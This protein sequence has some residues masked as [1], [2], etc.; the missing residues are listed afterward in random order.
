VTALPRVAS[1]SVPLPLRFQ[2]GARTLGSIRRRMVRV[3]LTL[4]D[5]LQTEVP[6]LPPLERGAHGYA[7]T[8]LP[9]A[10]AEGMARPGMLGFVRQSYNRYYT[11][12][13]IGFDAWFG[14]LS[15]SA[16]ATLK[17]KRRKLADAAGGELD[18]RAYRTPEDLALFHTIARRIS[19]RTY[20]ERLMGSGLPDDP[21]FVQRMYAHA[22]ADGVR[23][24]LLFVGAEP[25][26]YLFCESDGDILRYD[27]VGHDPA[28]ADLSPGQVLQ[29]EAF[30]DLFADRFARF[31]FTEGEGQ[32]KRQFSTGQVACVDLL[33]LRATPAN[34][35]T[36]LAL[37]GFDGLAAWGK[38]M[39]ARP[40][41]KGVAKRLR[42]AS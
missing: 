4:R 25:A 18:V 24:W 32:H 7:L 22:A 12:L 39:A 8:S 38:R 15:S 16:R 11:D 35:A 33:L 9:A 10:A 14:G 23:A 28:F 19:A 36:M 41:L 1:Q 40:A 2:I 6:V 26:A 29:V 20:Q 37:I 5:A 30:R 17:R 34:R 31:D 21:A 13:G 42:R 27:H 3:P